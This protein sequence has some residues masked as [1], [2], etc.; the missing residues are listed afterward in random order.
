MKVVRDLPVPSTGP[1][2]ELIA[3]ECDICG[4]REEAVGREHIPRLDIDNGYSIARADLCAGCL[5]EIHKALGEWVYRM[6]PI[7]AWQSRGPG[8]R[9]YSYAMRDAD[10][11]ELTYCSGIGD[12]HSGW[13][14]T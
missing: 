4:A 10:S 6:R 1:L 2:T 5:A 9:T 12:E 3:V 14:V 11:G 7:T 8:W 13:R